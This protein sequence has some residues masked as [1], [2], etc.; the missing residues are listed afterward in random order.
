MT[1]PSF[2]EAILGKCYKILEKKLEHNIK[3]NF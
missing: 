2:T 3:G 1:I